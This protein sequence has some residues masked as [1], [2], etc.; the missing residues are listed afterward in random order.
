MKKIGIAYTKIGINNKMLIT[1]GDTTSYLLDNFG[2]N[3]LDI[4]GD[5]IPVI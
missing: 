2:N 5:P 3:I 1:A 4:N